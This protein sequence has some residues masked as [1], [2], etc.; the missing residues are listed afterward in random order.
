M[1]M[2]E[3]LSAHEIEQVKAGDALAFEALYNKYKRTVYGLCLRNIK[4]AGDAEDLTQEVFLQVYR[5]VCTLRDGNAFKSWLFRVT[6][7]TIL[8]HARRRRLSPISL[9]YILESATS[10]VVGIVQ[11]LVSPARE[12]I[13]RIT[14]ARAIGGLPKR[15]RSVLVLHDIKGMTHR[16]IAA[17]LG[18]SIN[19]TKSNLSR[20]HH[21]LRS[22]LRSNS[23]TATFPAARGGV[24]ELH[25]GDALGEML[26][27]HIQAENYVDM[28]QTQ[29]AVA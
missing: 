13:E 4:N 6:T 15:R 11:T 8:M 23:T 22:I 1:G 5:R 10:A 12:P 3:G 26:G 7:N 19:T 21:Q 16:E 14:L 29:S 27:P 9:H 24:A 28:W 17:S 25:D 18:V 20:A 2:F